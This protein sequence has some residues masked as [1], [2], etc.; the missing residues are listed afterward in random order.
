MNHQDRTTEGQIHAHDG[1]HAEDRQN[2]ERLRR[3]RDDGR[4]LDEPYVQRDRSTRRSWRTWL[5]VPIAAVATLA[6]VFGAVALSRPAPVS[7]RGPAAPATGAAAAGNASQTVVPWA[8][9]AALPARSSTSAAPTFTPK[10][11]GPLSALTAAIELPATL[12]AG[13]TTDYTVR[14]TNSTGTA[15]ALTPCPSYTQIVLGAPQS[16]AN[17]PAGS[18]FRLNCASVGSLAAGASVTF[19]MRVTIPADARGETKVTWSLES[20]GAPSV[21]AERPVTP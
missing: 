19:A 6:I 9:L 10:G 5:P 8:P 18:R 20:P 1:M 14:L 11:S 16:A 7:D 2:V 3:L 17:R 4:W 15:I 21:V 12:H 13:V